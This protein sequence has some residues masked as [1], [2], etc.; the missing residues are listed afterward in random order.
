M[1]I[2]IIEDEMLNYRHLVHLLQSNEKDA[3]I[4]GPITS[5]EEI[6]DYFKH[7]NVMPDLI[8]ADIK[9]S[10]GLIFE[11]FKQ[12]DLSLPVIFTTAY[13]D[14]AIKAFKYNSIDYLLKPIKEDDLKTAIQKYQQMGNHLPT[15][16]SSYYDY[17]S[18][19]YRK[20]ILCPFRD[21]MVVIA[22]TQISYIRLEAKTVR[23]YLTN[24]QNYTSSLNLSTL[25]EE[26]DSNSFFRA[27]RNDIIQISEITGYCILP[28]RKATVSLRSYP[29]E[30]FLVSKERYPL[31]RSI[32]DK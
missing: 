25:E 28:D 18:K 31:L 11:A 27:N 8:M 1:K 22:V 30:R 15:K 13:D 29:N 5:N 3:E 17:V 20:R 21:K 26:L 2:L 7:R 10:D 4:I 23:I 12:L 19:P 9:L 24:Q 16:L 6:I 14:F 32:L